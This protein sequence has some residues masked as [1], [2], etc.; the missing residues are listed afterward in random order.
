MDEPDQDF[1]WCCT[2]CGEVKEAIPKD[3]P[4]RLGKPVMA[5]TCVGA[6]LFHDM[7]TG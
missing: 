3:A 2:M 7:L 6:N 1:K 5:A 4:E